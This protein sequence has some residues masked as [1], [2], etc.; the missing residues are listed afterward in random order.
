[1]TVDQVQCE[2]IDPHETPNLLSTTPPQNRQY[3]P[4]VL[5]KETIC[6]LIIYVTIIYQNFVLTHRLRYCPF[7]TV[8]YSVF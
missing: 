6:L 4:N 2:T 7:V 8:T 3:F 5:L 1:M